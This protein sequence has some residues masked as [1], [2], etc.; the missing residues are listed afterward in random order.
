MQKGISR[1]YVQFRF[2]CTRTE[3]RNAIQSDYRAAH[4]KHYLLGLT[5]HCSI[6]VLCYINCKMLAS[7]CQNQNAL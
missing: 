6:C 7:C 3:V 2:H 1:W 4:H 5:I